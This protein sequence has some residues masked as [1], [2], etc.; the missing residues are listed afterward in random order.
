[1]KQRNDPRQQAYDA[2]RFIEGKYAGS[3]Q[4]KSSSAGASTAVAKME[5]KK[6]GSAR[7][8]TIRVPADQFDETRKRA[9][10]RARVAASDVTT[11]QLEDTL[12]SG[13]DALAKNG[14]KAASKRR[15]VTQGAVRAGVVSAAIGGATEAAALVRGD[16]DAK[17]FAKRRA[18]EAGEAAVATT[19]GTA[20]KKLGKATAGGRAVAQGAARSAAVTVTV[21]SVRDVPALLRGDLSGRDFAEN[22]G[23]DAVEAAAATALGTVATG[24]VLATTGGAA[25]ATAVG[26]AAATAAASAALAAAG[27]GTLAGTAVA[28]VLGGVTATVAGP[29]IVGGAVV[30]GTG[31][32]VGKGF[33]VVRRRVKAHQERR[34]TPDPL[35][36]A[37][38]GAQP[39]PDVEVI[40]MLDG[41]NVFTTAERDEIVACLEQL[42]QDELTRQRASRRLHCLGFPDQRLVD[43]R[44]ALR[45]GRR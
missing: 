1:L 3:V 44:C 43:G 22:R 15:A 8:G 5:K 34:R 42:Q 29:A 24:A 39:V 17:T 33:K 30:V 12:S 16:V 11:E 7:Y 10:G 31:L 19:V 40:L 28:G 18:Q 35:T 32:V 21:S 26:G 4:H 13:L 45:F 27:T 25:A 41:K 6:P 37:S 9:R 23:V 2:D 36:S 14:T 38:L 20:A